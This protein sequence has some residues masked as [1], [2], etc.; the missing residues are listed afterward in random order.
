MSDIITYAVRLAMGKLKQ[1]RSASQLANEYNK[2]VKSKAPYQLV[3]IDESFDKL[4]EAIGDL[5]ENLV[6]RIDRF[7]EGLKDQIVDLCGDKNV[8]D[9]IRKMFDPI[10]VLKKNTNII[11]SPDKL[12]YIERCYE[13]LI[14]NLNSLSQVKPVV[15]PG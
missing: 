15:N 10:S 12:S 11:I 5:D 3:R 7:A 4:A 2:K 14:R 13:N 1:E 6:K 9:D 8:G